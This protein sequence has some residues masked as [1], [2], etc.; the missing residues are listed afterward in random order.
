MS[1]PEAGIGSRYRFQIEDGLLVPDPASRLQPEGVHGVSVVTDPLAWHWRDG[2]WTGRPLREAVFYEL[3]VGTFSA[4][5]SYAGV[6]QRLDYLADL[7]VTAIELMPVAAFA[8]C[9]NWGYDGVLPFA[10]SSCYGSP[11]DLKQ[12]VEAAHRKG[13]MV[14]LDVVYNHFGPEGNYLHLYASSFF[15]DRF[16]T[17]WGEAIRF[18]GPLCRWVRRFFIEN[19]LYWLEEFHFDGLRL[20]AVHAIFDDSQ[21]DILEELATAVREGPGKGR[22]VHLVLEND[23]NEVRYLA[24]EKGRP[25]FYDAQW[26]DDAHHA[27]HVLI[28]GETDG[29]YL[30]YA[31]N[32]AA[33]LGRCLAEG[34][35]Y[36]GEESAWRG[37]RRRG[38]PS[39]GLPPIAF[40][41]FHAESRP[42]RQPRLRRAADLSCRFRRAAVRH[43]HPAALTP[44]APAVHGPGM[45]LR[46]AVS[47]FLRLRR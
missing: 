46:P 19:A 23:G 26:N 11:D 34:F 40:V 28:S 42:D 10:P 2:D 15:T 21:P 9:R 44:A 30:D 17:P 5:G 1:G 41:D 3:H 8:G 27:M 37:G 12:L 47:L 32:P 20:D 18:S 35:A 29:Y 31:E 6:R 7:G 13:M 22:Q 14:F 24:R 43:R 4:A 38:S 33:R 16:D 39:A 25:S 45:G 36:Q